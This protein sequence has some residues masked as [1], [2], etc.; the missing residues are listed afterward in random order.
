M[1]RAQGLEHLH[2][3]FQPTSPLTGIDAGD[4]Q[5]LLLS[6]VECAAC[7]HGQDGAPLREQVEGAHHLGQQHG[8]TEGAEQDGGPQSH[9][10]GTG[11]ESGQGGE[12]LHPWLGRQAVADPHGI[13]ARRFRA[14][15]HLQHRIGVLRRFVPH[16]QRSCGQKDAQFQR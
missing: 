12:G 2:D 14:Q 13:Q 16:Y 7:A 10:L 1:P 5:L 3:F 6:L 15:G 11:R 9:P 4:T 8:M